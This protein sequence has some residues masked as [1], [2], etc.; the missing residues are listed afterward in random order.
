M[1]GLHQINAMDQ[2]P[3][4]P[5]SSYDANRGSAGHK[6][7][8]VRRCAATID[9]VTGFLSESEYTFEVERRILRESSM[10]T[11]QSFA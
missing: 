9:R 3:F 7:D 10:T 11:W 5:H 4:V 2:V 6:A 8:D 1:N